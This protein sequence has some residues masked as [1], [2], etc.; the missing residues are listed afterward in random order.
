MKELGSDVQAETF[1]GY[2]LDLIKTSQTNEKDRM[3][4]YGLLRSHW[5][6]CKKKNVGQECLCSAL[7][8]RIDMIEHSIDEE[9]LSR[10]DSFDVIKIQNQINQLEDDLLK[11]EEEETR[12]N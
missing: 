1:F 9:Q 3:I 8:Q 4:L 6:Q 7:V 11:L 10:N 12:K 2:L 5:Y